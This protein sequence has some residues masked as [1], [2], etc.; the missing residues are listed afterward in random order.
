MASGAVPSPEASPII[1]EMA[2]C[3]VSADSPM[4]ACIAYELPG[5]HLKPIC[6]ERVSAISVQ[7]RASYYLK[8]GCHC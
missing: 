4:A 7:G 6:D 8:A 2:P 5:S 3:N 1:P